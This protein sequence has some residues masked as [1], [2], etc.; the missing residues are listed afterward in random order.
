[1]EGPRKKASTSEQ[2]KTGIT[3]RVAH[4]NH[5][6]DWENARILDRDSNPFSRKIRESIEIRKMGAMAI[7]RDEGV[8]TLDH[9]YDPLLKSTL[10]PGKETAIVG[11]FP[12]KSSDSKHLWLSHQARWQKLKSV[13]KIFGFVTQNLHLLC[14]HF[15]VDK[16]IYWVDNLGQ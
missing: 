4:A 12:G 11:R 5:V 8:Y 6:I 16:I 10:H 9:V 15:S 13:S 3:D 1:M 14:A 2:H 7:N